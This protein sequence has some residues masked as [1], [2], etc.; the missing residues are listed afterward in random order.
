LLNWDNL[1]KF[2]KLGKKKLEEKK[3][4]I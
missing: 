4:K 2:K 1:T 3:K